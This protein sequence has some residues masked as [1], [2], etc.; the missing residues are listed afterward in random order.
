M[1]NIFLLFLLL[2]SLFIN[3]QEIKGRII[4]GIENAKKELTTALTDKNIHN[5]IENKSAIIK[6]SLTAVSIAQNILFP[7]YGKE[8][9]IKERP[10]E[11]YHITITG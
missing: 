4:I 11:I 5:V 10:Y 1:K 3:G 2:A 7:A 6:D 9:I 8:N